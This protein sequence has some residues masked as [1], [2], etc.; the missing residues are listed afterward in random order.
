MRTF[1]FSS[2]LL[3]MGCN[4]DSKMEIDVQGHRGCRALMPENSL[5][6]FQKA[7]DIGVNTLELDVVISKDKKVV[8]SHEPFMNH[9]IALDVSGNEILEAEEKSYNLYD[10]LYDSIKLY[11]CG[12]KPH[13][14]FPNQEKIKVHKPLLTEVIALAESE[15]NKTIKYNIEIKSDQEYDGVFT[16]KVSEFVTLVLDV[17]ASEGIQ[18][19]TSLQ[20]FDSRALEGIRNQ[21]TDINAVLLVDENETIAEKLSQLT[22]SPEVI[23]PYYKLLNADTVKRYQNKGY[24]II[25]WTV[26]LDE[27]ILEMVDFKVDGIIS[28]NPDRVIKILDELR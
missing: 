20:S 10:M 15:S 17:I 13:P 28:D 3:I 27:D 4:S 1:I 24:K 12:S 7:L 9:E 16:P 18:N 2:L 5:P 14:R 11:D 22:F 25:P 8:V 6:A 23:S 19:R 21:S 26:N